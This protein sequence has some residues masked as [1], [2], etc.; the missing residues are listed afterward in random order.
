LCGK[1]AIELGA[2]RAEGRLRGR[3]GKL[4]FAYLLL[5]RGRSVPRDELIEALW[6]DSHADHGALLSTLLS[7]QRSALPG[8]ELHGRHELQLELPADA[9]VDVDA[10][11]EA[12]A[13][14]EA[15]MTRGRWRDAW[16]P[17][18][19]A[20]AIT[21]SP[22]LPGFDAPWLV[23]RRRELEELLADALECM[24]WVG[25]R[26]GGSELAA[27]ERAARKLIALAPLRESGHV[28][29]MEVQ[30]AR[31][32]AAQALT[33]YEDLR[34]RL[35]E[36]LGATPG[37]AART[38]HARLLDPLHEQPPEVAASVSP[39]ADPLPAALRPSDATAFVGREREL[40]RLRLSL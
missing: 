29:L 3:Q 35:R 34:A 24:A 20:L 26:L 13:R 5:H 37:V 6:P 21:E 9:W 18:H 38:V 12:L 4:L 40:A 22:L 36:E 27:A 7:R 23:P 8:V 16:G 10:A 31:G 1:L 17:A 25:L 11:V 39:A 33:T 14:T 32:N 2:A 30:A 19:V 15:A 28:A